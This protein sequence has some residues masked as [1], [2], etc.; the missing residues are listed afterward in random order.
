MLNRLVAADNFKPVLAGVAGAGNEQVAVLKMK[1][2][3]FVLLQIGH[4]VDAPGG[5]GRAGNNGVDEILHARALHRH[6]GI[7]V[8]GVGE[9]QFAGEFRR[10]RLQPRHVRPD[11]RGIDD[12]QIDAFGKLVGIE[13]VNHAA[14]FVA[15]QGVLAEAGR[16]L[17][18]VIRQD[19]IKEA[20]RVRAAD[21]DFAHVGDV[22]DAGGVADGEMFLDD[23]GVLDRHFPAAEINQF[24]A[25]FLMCGEKC[26]FLQHISKSLLRYAIE[27]NAIDSH[28]SVNNYHRHFQRAFGTHRRLWKSHCIIQIV[29][30]FPALVSDKFIIG[31]L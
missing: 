9:S 12:E 7:I 22:E 26:R 5:H 6:G 17:A 11:A 31:N 1:S 23:A 2:A 3:D 4:G 15:H 21:S 28:L 16:Q 19:A 24:G 20:R 30:S 25:K 8:R 13:V 27:I 29:D 14:A 18:D 10:P